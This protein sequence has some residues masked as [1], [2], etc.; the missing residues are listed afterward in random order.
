MGGRYF[1]E[2]VR[3]GAARFGGVKQFGCVIMVRIGLALGVVLALA[4]CGDRLEYMGQSL[5]SGTDVVALST[6]SGPLEALSYSTGGEARAVVLYVGGSGCTSLSTY[7]AP[8]FGAA[9][10]GL[11]IHGVDKAGV[12]RGD[13]GLRCGAGFWSAYTYEAMLARNLSLYDGLRARHP[14]LP[15]AILGTSEGGA[16]A[17][18][19]AARVGG[20]V[21][22]AV[23]GAGGMPQREELHLLAKARGQE[24]ELEGLLARVAQSPDSTQDFALGM[25]HRYWSSVLDRDPAAYLGRIKAP[26]LIV[27]GEEDQSVPVASARAAARHLPN[28]ELV[29]WPG[30][31]HVFD[32]AQGSQRD[33][34]VARAGAFLLDS[35]QN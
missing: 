3:E 29:I 9:P 33:A 30:A 23:L 6:K 20:R 16:I 13:L 28:A 8:Y 11:L 25:S 2:V 22:V 1:G 24:A 7:M 18:D 17:L 4:G 19:L 12:D 27:I 32:T 5:R 15:I 35:L 26:V 34:A 31:D 10:E 14:G 21:P